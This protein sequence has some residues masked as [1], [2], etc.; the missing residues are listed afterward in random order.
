M[1]SSSLGDAI[2]MINGAHTI[3]Y[4]KD[5][6]A[7]RLFLRDVLALPNVDVG[8]GWLIFGLPPGEIA[9]HP[10]D[11]NDKHELYFMCDDVQAFIDQMGEREIACSPVASQGWGLLTSLTLPGGGKIGVYQPR[12]ERAP[13]M[14]VG[15]KKSAPAPR[16][17]AKAAKPKAKPKAAKAKPK[18]A[19]A[20]PRA[21]KAKAP[22]AKK[23]RRR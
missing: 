20:K 23:P 22:K 13:A 12:H 9:V 17:K 19:K 5:P 1:A 6:D 3:V 4:S 14:A 7:D 10:A 15:A 8:G 21:A 2:V 18:A 16:R 11:E